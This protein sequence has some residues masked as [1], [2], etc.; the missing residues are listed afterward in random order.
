MLE[1]IFKYTFLQWTAKSFSQS[2]LDHCESRKLSNA[3][4]PQLFFS[5]YLILRPRLE[6][7]CCRKIS[8]VRKKK[9]S[10]ATWTGTVWA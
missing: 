10:C 9:K 3:P 7:F 2:S 5:F 1:I 8:Q 6:I 4:K